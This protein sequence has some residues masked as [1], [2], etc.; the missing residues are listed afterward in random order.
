MEFIPKNINYTAGNSIVI[1]ALLLGGLL[2]M[3]YALIFKGLFFFICIALAPLAILIFLFGIKKPMLS[4]IL[5]IAISCYFSALYRYS[6]IQGLSGILEI[7]LLFCLFSLIINVISNHQTYPWRNGFNLLTITYF[8]WMCYCFLILLTPSA[9]V[10]NLLG[11]RSVFI[12]LPITYII[13]SI[14]LCSTKKIRITLYLFSIFV[15][16]AVFKAYWQKQKGF[17]STEI[18]WLLSGAWHTHILQSGI[19]YFSFFTDAGNFGPCMG[20][21][22]LIFGIAAS[23]SSKKIIRYYFLI[24]SL[25]AGIGLMMSGTRGAIVV[26]LGGIFLYFLMSKSI[27]TMAICV[28]VGSIIFSFFYFTD[29]GEENIFIRRMRTAF[30]PTEDASFNVRVENQKRFAYYL[31]D[32]PFGVGVGGVVVDTER[33]LILEEEFIPTD[34][35]YVD[36]W[37]EGGIVGLC[38]YIGLQ[39]TLLIWCC[40]IL[41][42]KVK[43]KQLRQLLSAMLCC[44]FGIWINGYVSRSFGFLPSS[45]I[46]A[47]FL[48]FIMNAIYIDRQIK[49]D[50]IIL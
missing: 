24:I 34:S 38:L 30:R 17:D 3:A 47:I 18:Q 2:A 9:N 33:L 15:V 22:T 6:G 1:Y 36:I 41:M 11:K 13:S 39:A 16:T 7:T 50:E 21:F 42:F 5:Y 26:P 35:F 46:I 49:K 48:S 10:S 19:R 14:L 8:I 25:L 27:K 45:I 29:I 28:I 20:L 23:V 31:Q 44:V 12:S 43:N 37:V 4:Y 32:K 40:Y